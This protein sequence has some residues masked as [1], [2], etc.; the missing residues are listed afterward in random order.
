MKKRSFSG[1]FWVFI[2]LAALFLFFFVKTRIV[3]EFKT[4]C[5]PGMRDQ[6]KYTGTCSGGGYPSCQANKKGQYYCKCPSTIT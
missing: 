5:T 6:C 4:S 2:V 3:E 1:F